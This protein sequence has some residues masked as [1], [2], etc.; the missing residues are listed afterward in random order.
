[1]NSVL[2]GSGRGGPCR[3]RPARPLQDA[4]LSLAGI[5]P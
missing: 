4:T 2:V 5:A 1:M 3:Q